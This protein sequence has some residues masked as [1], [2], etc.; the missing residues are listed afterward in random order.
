M[1]E[2]W[3]SPIAWPNRSEEPTL[4][5]GGAWRSAALGRLC[6]KGQSQ[7]WIGVPE[8]GLGR[9]QVD[10][11]CDEDGRIGPAEVVEDETL[12]AASLADREPDSVSP[13]RVVE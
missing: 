1:H 9:L 6:V 4:H 3:A 5:Q 10:A 8:T 2:P 11:F 7:A 13:V 12:K